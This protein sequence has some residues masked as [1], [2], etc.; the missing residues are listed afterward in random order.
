MSDAKSKNPSKQAATP[1][2]T[3]HW[4]DFCHRHNVSIPK[5]T[6]TSKV[7]RPGKTYAKRHG[8][9]CSQ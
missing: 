6:K 4:S 1:G 9:T 7:T 5:G 3:P 8:L 2:T